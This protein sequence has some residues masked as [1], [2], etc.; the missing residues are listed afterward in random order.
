MSEVASPLIQDRTLK[1]VLPT[2]FGQDLA[3]LKC[4]QG[5]QSG[6]RLEGF[7]LQPPHGG[8]SKSQQLLYL[9]RRPVQPG[10]VL[11]LVADVFHEVCQLSLLRLPCPSQFPHIV[12]LVRPRPVLKLNANECFELC[13]L[14][15]LVAPYPSPP[16]CMLWLSFSTDVPDWH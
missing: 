13:R 5:Q 10:P 2:I 16:L 4:V 3:L 6:M 7:A 14:P 9:N 11:K 15:S 8:A 12:S 1:E